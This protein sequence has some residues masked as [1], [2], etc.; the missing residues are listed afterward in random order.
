MAARQVCDHVTARLRLP[1]GV[2]DGA[3]PLP[4]V[5][6]VPVRIR[7]R[8]MVRVRV[9]VGVRIRVRRCR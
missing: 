1:E 5:I 7:V 3:P 9:R 2:D 4:D 8:V 6:V